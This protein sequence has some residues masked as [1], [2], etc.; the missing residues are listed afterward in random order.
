MSS[1]WRVKEDIPD[2]SGKVDLEQMVMVLQSRS[3]DLGLDSEGKEKLWKFIGRGI[4]HF[5]KVTMVEVCRVG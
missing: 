4:F 2:Y 1:A 3:K 5:R